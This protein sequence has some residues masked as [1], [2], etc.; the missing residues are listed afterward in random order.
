M[1]TFINQEVVTAYDKNIFFEKLT[2]ERKLE[3]FS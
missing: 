1:E 2:Y 3:L